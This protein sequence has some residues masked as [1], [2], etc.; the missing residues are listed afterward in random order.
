MH[1]EYLVYLSTWST[2]LDPNPGIDQM[3]PI[4]M[5]HEWY[6]QKNCISNINHTTANYFY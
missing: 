6:L 3:I 2:V 4:A 1:L 5:N